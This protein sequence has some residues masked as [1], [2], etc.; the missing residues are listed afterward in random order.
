MESV[1]QSGMVPSSRK[2]R[3][4]EGFSPVQISII[5]LLK[6]WPNVIAYW[7]IAERIISAYGLHVTED[8]V[9]G[10]LERLSRR[11]FLLRSRAA[12]GR[13]QGNRYA[14]SADPCPYIRA[15]TPRMEPGVDSAMESA[16]QPGE[17]ATPSILRG[18]QI[19]RKNLSLSE[20]AERQEIVRRLETLSEDTI[21]FHWPQLARLG[22]G[23]HQIRQI[24]HRLAQVNIGPERIVQGLTHAAWAIGAGM[25]HDKTGAPIAD[26]V[27]WVFSILARQGYY[28]RPKGY[29]SPQEQAELDA[30]EEKQKLVAAWTARIEAEFTAWEAGLSESERKAILT[31]R[32]HR[33]GPQHIALKEH[34]RAVIRQKTAGCDTDHQSVFGEGGD[35]DA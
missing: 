27:S 35:Q 30:A 8:V 21:A 7:Q 33:F 25:M 12:N 31:E 10:A 18:E 26:P 23:T 17:N 28:P 14:F 34:F 6:G 32:G 5:S 3:C 13:I 19:D 16:A 4:L 20:E 11:G 24:L 2:N 9:R 22:F 15:Y 29:V 1:V